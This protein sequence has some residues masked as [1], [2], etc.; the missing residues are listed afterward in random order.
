[1]YMK[2]HMAGVGELSEQK[3]LVALVMGRSLG[4]ISEVSGCSEKFRNSVQ[5]R[6]RRK[7]PFFSSPSSSFISPA[8]LA[9]VPLRCGT[10]SPSLFC[11]SLPPSM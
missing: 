3:T 4:S 6:C 2:G 11:T 7:A 5:V 9:T 1:M 8:F 10:F